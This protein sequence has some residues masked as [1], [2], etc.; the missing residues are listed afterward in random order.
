MYDEVAACVRD[1]ECTEKLEYVRLAAGQARGTI[2][3]AVTLVA[4]GC[5][6]HG[7]TGE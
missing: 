2:H 5:R 6:L 4:E 1:N 3:S 7:G